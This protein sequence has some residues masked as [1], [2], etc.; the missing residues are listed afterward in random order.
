MTQ[1]YGN[2]SPWAA[3]TS[4]RSPLLSGT[5]E[6]PDSFTVEYSIDGGEPVIEVLPN[7]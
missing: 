2:V 6:V 5:S 1:D 4:G 7:V 3:S